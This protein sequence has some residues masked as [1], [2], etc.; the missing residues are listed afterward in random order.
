MIRRKDKPAMALVLFSLS[1]FCAVLAFIGAL[2]YDLYLASTQWILVG[3][4]LAAWAVYME[5]SR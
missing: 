5:V 4:L 2:G 3:I 1:L